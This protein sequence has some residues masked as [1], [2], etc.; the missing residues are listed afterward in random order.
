MNNKSLMTLVLTAVTFVVGYAFLRYAYKV[1]DSFPFTQEIVLIILGTLVTVLITALLLNK[2]TEV[3]VEKE[4]AIKFLDLKTSTYEQ[5]IRRIE[6]M[7]MVRDLTEDDLMRMR[8]ITHRLAIFSSPEVLDEYHHF[9]SVLSDSTEDGNI[10]DDVSDVST[11]LAKLTVA[12]RADLLGESDD[13]S[14]HSQDSIK[15]MILKNVSESSD[16]HIHS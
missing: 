6:D 2:Q 10:S 12:I 14:G 4:Q 15:S 16:L 5:L 11:A 3:E 13:I 8:F 9:L 1:T 7:S